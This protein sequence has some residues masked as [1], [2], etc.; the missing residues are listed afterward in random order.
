MVAGEEQAV[1]DLVM[2][3]FDEFVRPDFSAGGVKEFSASAHA[4]VLERPAGHSIVVAERDGELVG[5]L[6]LRDGSHIALFFVESAHQGRGVGAALLDEAIGRSL[7]HGADTAA[8]TVNSAPSAVRAYRSL[9]FDATAPER[10]VNGIRFVAMRRGLSR[11][12]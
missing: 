9:G 10:D 5:M 2:R 8:I 7:A 1:L 6:D 12:A 11:R 3:V 4:F